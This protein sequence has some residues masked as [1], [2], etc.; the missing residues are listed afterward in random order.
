MKYDPVFLPED[1]ALNGSVSAT[2]MVA[3]NYCRRMAFL[4]QLHKGGATEPQLEKGSVLHRAIELATLDVIDRGGFYDEHGVEGVEHGIPPEV[5]KAHMDAVLAD[6]AYHAPIEF[7][8][9]LRECLWRWASYTRFDPRA[10]V[11][12]QLIALELGDWRIRMKIDFL[13][14]LGG[15]SKAKIRDFKSSRSAPSKEDVART[16]RDGRIAPKDMQLVLYALGAK[17]GRPIL[18]EQDA[19]GGRREVEQPFPLAERASSFDI[20]YS[21]PGIEDREHG[22]PLERGGELTLSELVEYR[23]SV[24]A[25]LAKLSEVVASG[26]WWPS[27]SDAHCWMCP[28]QA[29]CPIPERMRKWAPNIDTMEE[30]AAEAEA[31]QLDAQHLNARRARLRNYVKR[32]PGQR[33]R[34]GRDMVIEPRA[35]T[36]REVDTDGLVEAAEDAARYGRAFVPSSFIKHKASQPIKP[37]RMTEAELAEE[38]DHGR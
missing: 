4:Y 31:I 8:D 11:V 21:F 38:E 17:W 18:V 37:R 35:Q 24:E 26:E 15:G 20:A 3:W 36:A 1:R 9:Y 30:A 27:Q 19:L 33:L 2:F 28:S 34:F 5:A 12:E 10:V 29:D 16:L 32:L 7:H 25:A 14:L 13:E 23:A 6:P 22:G